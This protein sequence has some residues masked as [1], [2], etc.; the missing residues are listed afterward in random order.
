MNILHSTWFW[1]AIIVGPIGTV[2]GILARLARSEAPA[3][4][5]T[6]GTGQSADGAITDP[7]P[8]ESTEEKDLT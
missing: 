6:S 2:V 5:R 1:V 8:S 7:P 3:R 4:P